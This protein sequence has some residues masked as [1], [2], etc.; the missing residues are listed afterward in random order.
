MHTDRERR[1]KKKGLLLLTLKS[2]ESQECGKERKHWS[3]IIVKAWIDDCEHT[4]KEIVFVNGSRR[5]EKTNCRGGKR[6]ILIASH[7]KLGRG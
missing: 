7:R 3:L 4:A 5:K 1:K 6:K 2:C